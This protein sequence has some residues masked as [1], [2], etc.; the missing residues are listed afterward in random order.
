MVTAS[1]CTDPMQALH[2]DAVDADITV[3]NEVI[4][5]LLLKCRQNWYLELLLCLSNAVH[6]HNATIIF[7]L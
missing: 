1:Y 7:Y 5:L 6:L 2:Q 3:V 4:G